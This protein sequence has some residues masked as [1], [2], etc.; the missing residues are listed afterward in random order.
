MATLAIRRGKKEVIDYRL[1]VAESEAE[2]EAFMT[3]LYRAF[4][5]TYRD[6]SSI[7][8]SAGGAVCPSVREATLIALKA[9]TVP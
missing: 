3:D 1:C 5:L 4:G 7:L 8:A 9:P 6:I 2:W